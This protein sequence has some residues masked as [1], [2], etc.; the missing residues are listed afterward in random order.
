MTYMDV[1]NAISHSHERF[2]DALKYAIYTEQHMSISSFA[3]YSSIPKSTLYKIIDGNREPTLRAVRDILHSIKR[4]E[5]VT[6]HPFIAVIA[7]RSV[8]ETYPK[9][10]IEL[11]G[12]SYDVREFS[13]VTMEDAILAAVTADREG[14][15]AIVCAPIVSPS[16]DRLVKIPVVT[17]M[18][19]F[20][21]EE[22]IVRAAEKLSIE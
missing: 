5:G 14:A 10:R 1:L 9:K 4:L 21:L 17:M 8:L 20:A 7:A 6:D 13:A 11:S 22:A 16:I 18:P 12:T 15:L 2:I 19:K 3:E